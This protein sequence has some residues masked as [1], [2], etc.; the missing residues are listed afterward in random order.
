MAREQE[1]LSEWRDYVYLPRGCHSPRGDAGGEAD[2]TKVEQE[3]GY[4]SPI[5]QKGEWQGAF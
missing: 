3:L 2:C 1:K 5:G 4:L